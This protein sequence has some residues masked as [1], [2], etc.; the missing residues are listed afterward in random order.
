[1]DTSKPPSPPEDDIVHVVGYE[2]VALRD[3]DEIE[4]VAK[5]TLM[6]TLESAEH[7]AAESHNAYGNTRGLDVLSERHDLK[8]RLASLE[9]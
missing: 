1:M 2:V 7:E 8:R 6:S 3:D 4:T 5:S 9:D